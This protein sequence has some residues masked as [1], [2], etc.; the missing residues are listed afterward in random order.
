VGERWHRGSFT[1][2]HEHLASDTVRR[3]LGWIA[4]AYDVA[5][6][7]P[8]LLVATPSTEMHELGAMLAAAAA[9]GE[10]WR[11]V[12]LG[13]NLPA[14]DLVGAASKVGATAIALSVV[15]TDGE[16]ILRELRATAATLPP[17]TVMMIGGPAAMRLERLLADTE[18]RVVRDIEA[19]RSFLREHRARRSDLAAD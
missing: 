5:R 12:Y 11:V 17:E 9:A 3:V 8:V 7:A 13:P 4:E 10:G 16:H 6:D 2:A 15:Y 14:A 1:P 18:I 19:L